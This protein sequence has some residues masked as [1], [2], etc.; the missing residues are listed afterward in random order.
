MSVNLLIIALTLLVASASGA[1][2]RPYLEQQHTAKESGDVDVPKLDE[3]RKLGQ[4]SC[5][6]GI[7]LSSFDGDK[8]KA[9]VMGCQGSWEDCCQKCGD[10]LESSGKIS[11]GWK[12]WYDFWRTG[13][14]IRGKDSW[15]KMPLPA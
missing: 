1:L 7:Y 4:E 15:G 3:V 9:K 13:I 8:T 11:S 12:C 5:G 6:Q 10:N 14:F 2:R